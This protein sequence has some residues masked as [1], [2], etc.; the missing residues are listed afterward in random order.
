MTEG[1]HVKAE[2]SCFKLKGE[3][4]HFIKHFTSSATIL[5][6]HVSVCYWLLGVFDGHGGKRCAEFAAKQFPHMFE[7][8]LEHGLQEALGAAQLES[9]TMLSKFGHPAINQ[10]V[11][12]DALVKSAPTAL[13]ASFLQ[14]DAEFLMKNVDSGTTATVSFICG[15]DVVT[16]NVGDSLAFVDC[17]S[18]VHQLS[19]NHRIDENAAERKRLEAAGGDIA[20]SE[21]DGHP[22][23]PLRIWPGG[24]AMSRTIG[25]RHAGARVTAEPSVCQVSIGRAGARLVLASDGLWDAFNNNGKSVCHRTRDLQC[26]KAAAR[27]R[28]AAKE[29][30]DRDDITVIC[31]D[32]LPD[33]SVRIPPALSARQGLQLCQ[34][35]HPS[36]HPNGWCDHWAR[37]MDRRKTEHFQQDMYKEE[38]AAECITGESKTSSQEGSQSTRIEA[39]CIH[40]SSL[41]EQVKRLQI[42]SSADEDDKDWVTVPA[43]RPQAHDPVGKPSACNRDEKPLAGK[44]ARRRNRYNRGRGRGRRSDQETRAFDV[45]GGHDGP[46]EVSAVDPADCKVGAEAGGEIFNAEKTSRG[47]GGRLGRG[48]RRSLRR[49]A[50]RGCPK[51]PIPAP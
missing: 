44:S 48:D 14:V 34:V 49:T 32:L 43:R 45:P 24:L 37:L 38:E 10:L 36:E 21:V 41:Y 26:T 3:D 18:E 40:P 28:S 23:G 4:F 27:L 46:A 47:R 17:G 13:K 9:Y 19:G 8:H 11:L 20:S 35:W 5:D 6:D 1:F 50:D 33:T 25:D 2:I 7:Q 51:N 39:Q 42:T 16:A 30:R 29:K 22:C 31:V 12:Q 15:A